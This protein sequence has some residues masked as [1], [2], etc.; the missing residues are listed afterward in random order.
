MAITLFALT[1]SGVGVA[2]FPVNIRQNQNIELTSAKRFVGT[3]KS[4]L[5]RGDIADQ[6]LIFKIEGGRLT[7]TQREVLFRKEKDGN[8]KI[9]SDRYVD[10]PELSV[11]GD[12]ITWMSKM[13]VSRDQGPDIELDILNRVSLVGDDEILF[14][15]SGK[16]LIDENGRQG[17][18]SVQVGYDLKREK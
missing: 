3:W 11:N 8:Q 14:E 5:K 7:G 2:A 6:V 16:R 15:K 13:K 18:V 4:N 12:A 10:L 1:L 9:E 17:G